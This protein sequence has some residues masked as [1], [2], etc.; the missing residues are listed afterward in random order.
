[1]EINQV[2]LTVVKDED[3]VLWVAGKFT[4]ADGRQGPEYATS[5]GKGDA[6]VLLRLFNKLF[7]TKHTWK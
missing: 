6:Q 7:G 2:T 3:G 4:Q 1:M 5:I